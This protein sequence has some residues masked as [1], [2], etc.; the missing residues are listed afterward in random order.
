[1]WRRFR[2]ALGPLAEAGKL[3]Y[4]LL[5]LPKWFAPSRESRVYLEASPAR[6]PGWPVAIEF[7]QAGW[8]AEERRARTLALLARGGLVYVAVE[9]PQRTRASVPPVAGAT[10]EALAVVRFHGR[11]TDAWDRLGASTT[12]RFGYLYREDELA[13]WVERVR[14]L[15][16][17][18]RE[19][20]VL[21]RAST[22]T[23]ISRS[24][25]TTVR[26]SS[27]C[28]VTCFAPRWRRIVF[29]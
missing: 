8:M 10:T 29:R 20:H 7:R 28:A 27:A 3:A 4:V 19:V 26:G 14:D 13:E 5:Q 12:E 24:R 11:R 1:M 9:E 16:G 23:R 15:A 18:S 2:A 25:P 17:R 6:L 22:S 21:T